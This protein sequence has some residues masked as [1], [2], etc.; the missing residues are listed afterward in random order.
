MAEGKEQS[1]RVYETYLVSV[2]SLLLLVYRYIR[3]MI[4]LLN[5][6]FHSEL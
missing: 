1:A 2:V 4:G 3:W 6:H 5:K